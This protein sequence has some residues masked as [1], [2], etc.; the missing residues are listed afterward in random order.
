MAYLSGVHV[1][2]KDTLGSGIGTHPNIAAAHG[3]AAG[4]A[5]LSGDGLEYFAVPVYKPGVL[6]QILRL[7][8]V[9]AGC[10]LARFLLLADPQAFGCDGDRVRK[11]VRA[12]EELGGL[13]PT[14]GDTAIARGCP[15]ASVR[16]SLRE[17]VACGAEAHPGG[18]ARRE[19]FPFTQIFHKRSFPWRRAAFTVRR[20]PVRC[21]AARHSPRR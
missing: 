5:R 14:R 15:R 11:S 8:Q 4:V 21:E 2:L 13:R 9:I 18:E 17:R 20:P 19:E 3:H 12:F 6:G 1:Y 16:V 10:R 7:R